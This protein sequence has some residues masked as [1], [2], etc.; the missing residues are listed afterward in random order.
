[1]TD[2]QT[3][4]IIV[5]EAGNSMTIKEVAELAEVST[6]AVSR[7][8]N[9]GSLSEDKRKRIKK[10]VEKNAYMPNVMAK[11]MRT[12]R[13]GQIGVIIP[14][15]QSH[16]MSRVLSG[17]MEKL[18]ERGYNIILCCTFGKREKEVQF[19]NSMQQ[20]RLEGIVLMGTSMTPMLRET[21]ADCT[22]PIV[23]TGQNFKNVP[24]VYHDDETAMYDMAKRVL[25]KRKNVV[26]IGVDESDPATGK[27]RKKGV[28]KAF[29]EAG[30]ELEDV[31][32][33][34]SDYSAECGYIAGQE[35]LKKYPQADGVICASDHIAHGVLRALKD[36][37]KKIPKDI[38]ITGVGDSWAD[39]ITNPTL[40]TVELF[41]EECGN[42]AGTLLLRLIDEPDVT[43]AIDR[44]KL[45]YSI[46][47]RGSI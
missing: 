27:A 45:G 36:A 25:A 9:G 14:R 19:I 8:F 29:R 35:L 28:L 18:D 44:I 6:A 46:L 30:V 20:G 38:G 15:I 22:I 3:G 13:S 16:S 2:R 40:T 42:V 7:Y 1:M 21:I 47:E 24:C 39:M 43:H 32:C 12:G 37:G 23:V 4:I 33:I 41:Y 26:F 34:I 11:T 31:P 17:L 5:K 10:V